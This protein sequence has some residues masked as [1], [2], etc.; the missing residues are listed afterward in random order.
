MSSTKQLQKIAQELQSVLA[1]CQQDLVKPF[2]MGQAM[3]KVLEMVGNSITFLEE[4]TKRT[5]D[6][7]DLPKAIEVQKK[8][9]QAAE[10]KIERF[11]ELNPEFL[12]LK[13]KA[14]VLEKRYEAYKEDRAKLE[15]ISQ[16][17]EILERKM[18]ELLD[19][20]QKEEEYKK[21]LEDYQ[22]HYEVNEKILQSMLKYNST[23]PKE[24]VQRVSQEIKLMLEKFDQFLAHLIQVREKLPVYEL[25]I[26]EAKLQSE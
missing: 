3:E 15:A 17:S 1:D 2:Q 23:S 6:D 9:Y 4:E 5:F 20:A 14:E 25:K 16:R 13:K 22:L 8:R 18:Q 10:R 19:I 7:P 24:D 12:E 21:L 26:D 11:F